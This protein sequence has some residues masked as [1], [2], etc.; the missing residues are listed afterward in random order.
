LIYKV[1]S[2]VVRA[3]VGLYGGAGSGA[4]GRVGPYRTFQ[5]IRALGKIHANSALGGLDRLSAVNVGVFRIFRMVG[6]SGPFCPV[7]RRLL[8]RRLTAVKVLTSI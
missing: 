8:Y 1:L 7:S 2:Q 4:D 5:A 6:K 3:L